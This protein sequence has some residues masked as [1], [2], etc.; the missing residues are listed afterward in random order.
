MQPYDR[1]HKTEDAIGGLEGGSAE[2]VKDEDD[3]EHGTRR[4]MQKPDPRMPSEEERR[5]HELTHLPF[6]NWCRH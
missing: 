2:E 6:R 1:R 3:G 5:E 4:P